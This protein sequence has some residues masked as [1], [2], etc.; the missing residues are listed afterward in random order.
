MNLTQLLLI[1]VR[2]II[3]HFFKQ[4]IFKVIDYIEKNCKSI[5]VKSMIFYAGILNEK[6]SIYINNYLVL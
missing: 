4:Y 6:L 1:I 2:F 3:L 5:D